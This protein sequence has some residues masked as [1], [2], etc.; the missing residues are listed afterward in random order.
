MAL[1]R[2][3]VC[4]LS[5]TTA[6]LLGCANVKELRTG[7]QATNFIVNI[8]RGG[9]IGGWRLATGAG[10]DATRVWAERAAIQDL[11][12]SVRRE[13]RTWACEFAENS[14]RLRSSFG[15]FS[16]AD[17]RSL[18]DTATILG[19]KSERVNELLSDVLKLSVPDLSK[20][21]AA[22]CP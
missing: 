13:G 6:L 18:A 2:L 20:A 1:V 4:G 17:R 14:I 16:A 11:G 15:V 12:V 7:E 8:A 22:A 9:A 10:G 3:T 21:T 5:L 19:A